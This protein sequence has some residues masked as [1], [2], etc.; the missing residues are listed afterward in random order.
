MRKDDKEGRAVRGLSEKNRVVKEMGMG[1]FQR[2][3]EWPAISHAE[4][5]STRTE[6]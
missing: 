4:E 1:P 3:M 5:G 6:D 2:R